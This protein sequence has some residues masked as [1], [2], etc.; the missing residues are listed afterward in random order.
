MDGK[1]VI[2]L[3]G[4]STDDAPSSPCECCNGNFATRRGSTAHQ[5]AHR[6]ERVVAKNKKKNPSAIHKRKKGGL[7][8]SDQMH[9]ALVGACKSCMESTSFGARVSSVI[10][11]TYLLRFKQFVALRRGGSSKTRVVDDGVG[12]GGG[13]R[14]LDSF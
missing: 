12:V 8:T 4:D 14:V 2:D 1:I 5:M 9:R 6:V 7:K 11:Q 10:E 13:I 3:T